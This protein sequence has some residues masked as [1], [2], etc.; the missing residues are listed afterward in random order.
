MVT[1]FKRVLLLV[2]MFCSQSLYAQC[3]PLFA[4]PEFGVENTWKPDSK[5]YVQEVNFK[6][7]CV[8]RST[9]YIKLGSVR[10][11]CDEAYHEDLTDSCKKQYQFNDRLFGKCMV[12]VNKAAKLVKLEGGQFFRAQK[13]KAE[14]AKREEDRKARADK[15]RK[16]FSERAEERRKKRMGR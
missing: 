9:C 4:S 16:S 14:A 10:N 8:Q 2:F 3:D 11:L 1:Y 13:R 15:R 7:A 12:K 6:K 5:G